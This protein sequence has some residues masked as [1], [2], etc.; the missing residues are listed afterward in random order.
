MT[1]HAHALQSHGKCP[2]FSFRKSG[3]PSI[4]AFYKRR[5]C[6]YSLVCVLSFFCILCLLKWTLSL[7]IKVD[8]DDDDDD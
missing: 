5:E 1:S 8:D 4:S 6:F 7:I 3:H 2:G